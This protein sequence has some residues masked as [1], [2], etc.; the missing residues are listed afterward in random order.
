MAGRLPLGLCRHLAAMDPERGLVP[1]RARVLRRGN[2]L[3][4][5]HAA[6]REQRNFCW[7][8]LHRRLLGRDADHAARRRRHRKGDELGFPS[9]NGVAGRGDHDS[10]GDLDRPGQPDRLAA[11]RRGGFRLG[12]VDGGRSPASAILSSHYRIGRHRLSRRHHSVVR[13]RRSARGARQRNVR[14]QAPIPRRHVDRVGG[15]HLLFTLG[16]FA[17]ATVLPDAQINLQE[18]L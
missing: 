14:P 13:R 11:P 10:G 5:W 16:S 9:G 7:R 2:R 3:C 8:L 4:H 15:G 18:G 17:V 6:T 1:D 12:H